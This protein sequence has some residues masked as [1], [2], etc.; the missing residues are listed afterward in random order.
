[1]KSK[2]KVQYKKIYVNVIDKH[3][4]PGRHLCSGEY[5]QYQPEFADYVANLIKNDI[6]EAI[7]K[8]SYKSKWKPLSPNYLEYKRQAGLSTKIWK[9]TGTLESSI[10]K[11][12]RKD[13][14]WVGVTANRKYPGTQLSM[15]DMAKKLEFGTSKVPARPLFRLVVNKYTRH[16]RKYW[17]EFKKSKGIK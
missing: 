10:Y 6:V 13:K 16:M 8:Q 3:F 1:M 17:T 11:L 14:I 15:L 2:S 4:T 5:S 7:E 12:N 9:A